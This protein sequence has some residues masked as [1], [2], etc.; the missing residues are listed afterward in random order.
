MNIRKRW[1][2]FWGSRKKKCPKGCV[3]MFITSRA[4]YACRAEVDGHDRWIKLGSKPLKHPQCRK[5][6]PVEVDR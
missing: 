1:A 2:A 3:N 5:A 6:G 4:C